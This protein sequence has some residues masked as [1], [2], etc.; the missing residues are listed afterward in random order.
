MGFYDLSFQSLSKK[1]LL[2]LSSKES[3]VAEIFRLDCFGLGIE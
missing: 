1:P 2:V 3:S